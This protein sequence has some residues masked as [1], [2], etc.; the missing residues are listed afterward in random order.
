MPVHRSEKS[1]RAESVR[2][3]LGCLRKPA[4]HRRRPLNLRRIE[5][6]VADS[7]TRG[8]YWGQRF[9]DH[10]TDVGYQFI[11]FAARGTGRSSCMVCHH[12]QR[13]DQPG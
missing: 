11:A 4:E 3:D 6:S 1:P 9:L 7:V 10:A 12:C 2:G 13:R 8:S 5:F